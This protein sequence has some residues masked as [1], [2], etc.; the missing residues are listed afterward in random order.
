M[1]VGDPHQRLYPGPR[2]VLERCGIRVRGK[3]FDQAHDLLPNSGKPFVGGPPASWTGSPSTAPTT[4]RCRI[5]RS[6]AR[7][8]QSAPHRLC[9]PWLDGGNTTTRFVRLVQRIAAGSEPLEGVCIVARHNT[10]L[11]RMQ[12]MT[13]ALGR[14]R[15]TRRILR[16]LRCR[17]NPSASN[18][19]LPN[20]PE[21]LIPGRQ[22]PVDQR[23]SAVAT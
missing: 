4:R 19:T 3:N 15:W 13:A 18:L 8:L 9:V 22:Q 21:L 16:S 11:A 5:W 20:S 17:P 2:V 1:L 12:R 10:I 7:R 6:T 23:A 14:K